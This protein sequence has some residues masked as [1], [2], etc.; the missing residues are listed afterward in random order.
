MIKGIDFVPD[1]RPERYREVVA[2]IKNDP[3]SLGALVTTHKMN[4]LKASRDLFDYIDPYAGTLGEVSSISKRGPELRG[5]A[6]DPITVGSALA[7]LVADGY[8]RTS[9]RAC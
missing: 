2:F 9:A 5:H 4:L 6:K 8:W 3:M 7:A 1:D